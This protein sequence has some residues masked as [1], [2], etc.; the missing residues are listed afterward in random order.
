MKCY[1]VWV[2]FLFA[3]KV[4]KDVWYN[5]RNICVLVILHSCRGLANGLWGAWRRRDAVRTQKWSTNKQRHKT[6]DGVYSTMCHS[7]FNFKVFF[8]FS[9][10]F[11]MKQQSKRFVD[12]EIWIIWF[13]VW[14]ARLPQHLLPERGLNAAWK[15]TSDGIIPPIF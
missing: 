9:F 10:F 5:P 6:V 1:S 7:A 11:C 8:V 14:N 2:V 13:P 3:V 15:A 4:R 12:C